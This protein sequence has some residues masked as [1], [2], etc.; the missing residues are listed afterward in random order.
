MKNI[1]HRSSHHGD[2]NMQSRTA[3]FVS[4]IF[5]SLVAGMP[6]TTV[7]HSAVPAADD[8]LSKPKGQAPEG[9]HWYYHIDRASKRHCWY[10]GDQREK[11]SRAK[12]Q[13]SAPIADPASPQKETATQRPVADAYAELPLPQTRVEQETNSARQRTPATT[14]NAASVENG[15]GANAPDAKTQLS[16]IA[17]RWPDPS[18]VSSSVSPAPTTGN[19]GEAVQLNTEQAPVLNA[20]EAPLPAVATSAAAGLLP[21][22]QSGSVQMLLLVMVGALVLAGV[23]GSAIFRFG[24]IR[25]AGRRQTRSDRRAIW[26]SVDTDR[27]SPPAYPRAEASM[28]RVDIPRELREA[29]DPNDRIAEMLARLSKGA[30]T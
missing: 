30:A 12:P 17:S 23:M 27:P 19:S 29:D 28:R 21:E 25:Q 11:L 8:C 26:D 10:L 15:Q 13:N 14:A 7:S 3:K 20:R 6:I 1:A 4:A 22:K 18:G 9:S 24:S 16:V 2:A 5:A